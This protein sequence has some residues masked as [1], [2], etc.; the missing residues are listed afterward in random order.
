[1]DPLSITAASIAV[2]QACSS[3]LHICY[4]TRAILRNKVW[5]LTKVQDEVVELRN[6]LEAIFRM[7]VNDQD[8]KISQKEHATLRLLSQSQKARGPL[9]LCLED[10]RTLEETLLAKYTSEPRT[11]FHA[12]MRAI[13]WDLS[14][15]E[16]KPIIDRLARSKAALNLA[17]S[18]DEV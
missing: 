8:S 15:R 14:E 17:I 3:I 2:L 16:I 18:A 13:S 12:V 9:V 4:N 5:C 6:V 1:M 7:A 10:L 11:T